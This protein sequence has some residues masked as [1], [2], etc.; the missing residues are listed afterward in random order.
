MIRQAHEQTHEAGIRFRAAEQQFLRDLAD[1]RH[2]RHLL[3]LQILD[4]AVELGDAY[5]F[6]AVRRRVQL[7]VRVRQQCNCHHLV[8]HGPRSPR[9]L[10][11]QTSYTGQQSYLF[12][13]DILHFPAKGSHEAAFCIL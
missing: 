11:R 9:A 5:V 6:A 8:A 7:R 1:H 10:H 4:D 2:F 12:H 3:L 13:S